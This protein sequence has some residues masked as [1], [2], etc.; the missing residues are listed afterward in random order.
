MSKKT[1]K[2]K[3]K[4]KSRAQG[5][6][7]VRR[8]GHS[9]E[10]T[11]AKV[12]RPLYPDV[13]RHLENQRQEALGFDLDNTGPF[14]FQCKAYMQYAPVT[15][16]EEVIHNKDQMPALI[17]KADNKRPVVCLYLDDFVKVLGDV[18]EAFIGVDPITENDF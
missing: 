6:A 10:R 9:F 17:T 16:I 12:L 2:P 13:K 3:V 8:K 7:A 1:T 15:K 5:G 4:K 18:G 11:C 14:L